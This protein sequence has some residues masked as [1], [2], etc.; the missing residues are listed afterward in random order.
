ME[1]LRPMRSQAVHG[2]LS[3][4]ALLVL[5][6]SGILYAVFWFVGLNEATEYRGHASPT[7]ESWLRIASFGIRGSAGSVLLLWLLTKA[8][9]RRA[10]T[11][12][13]GEATET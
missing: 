6:I 7:T 5:V 12:A 2:W 3:A 9:E 8:N 4:A 11:A 1:I 10:G 13:I